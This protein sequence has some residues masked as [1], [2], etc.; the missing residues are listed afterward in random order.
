MQK[1]RFF[2][3]LIVLSG[4]IVSLFSGRTLAQSSRELSELYE[5]QQFLKLRQYYEG[6]QIHDSNWKRFIEALSEDDADSAMVTFAE[7]Y[8]TTQDRLL[9]KHVGERIS[10]YYYAKG[11]YRTA[12]RLL[13]DKEF[14]EQTVSAQPEQETS[15]TIGYG[16][17]V[18]A[19]GNYENALALKNKMLK[20]N[21]NVTIVNKN[22]EGGNLFLVVIGK[23]SEREV[24]ERE[25]RSLRSN[26]VGGFIIQY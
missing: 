4:L 25:L 3:D 12:E 7:V 17:Q 6:N 23:F 21:R 2:F 9:K 11:Y 15:N 22:A 5:N 18:G 24:A 13:R 19:F 10:D 1:R 8:R 20:K 26:N 16:I 14:L